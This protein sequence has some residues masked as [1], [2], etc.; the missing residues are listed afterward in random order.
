[1]PVVPILGTGLSPLVKS[2]VVPPSS[3]HPHAAKH[4]HSI[5]QERELNPEEEVRN[6]YWR[7]FERLRRLDEAD[8]ILREYQSDPCGGAH[9]LWLSRL[10]RRRR[11]DAALH[12][13]CQDT[14]I[15]DQANRATA[16]AVAGSRAGQ[17]GGTGGPA[18]PCR[19][20]RGHDRRAAPHGRHPSSPRRFL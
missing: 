12:K 1:M 8:P 4:E 5:R 11:A 7:S 15:L 17:F 14:K 18:P 10:W 9:R 3:I 13:A 19:G 2:V 20:S 16:R 6:E